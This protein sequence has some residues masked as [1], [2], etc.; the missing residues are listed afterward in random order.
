M[1]KWVQTLAKVRVAFTPVIRFKTVNVH[2]IGE[3][4]FTIP[5]LHGI[6]E[7]IVVVENLSLSLSLSLSLVDAVPCWRYTKAGTSSGDGTERGERKRRGEKGNG[8]N[9]AMD[10]FIALTNL[11]NNF[12]TDSPPPPSPSPAN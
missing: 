3:G 11:I 9:S 2:A 4:I 12:E 1:S 10:S 8:E 7:I 6:I 5:R